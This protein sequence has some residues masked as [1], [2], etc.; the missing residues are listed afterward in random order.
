MRPNYRLN[1]MMTARQFGVRGA[2]VSEA[3][4]VP[5]SAAGDMRLFLWTF[6]S[7]FLFTTIFLA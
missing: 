7:G 2:G 5:S 4:P 6:A 3:I 1:R